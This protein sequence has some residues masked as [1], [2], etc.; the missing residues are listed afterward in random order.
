MSGRPLLGHAG[1]SVR[2]RVDPALE[3][4]PLGTESFAR[5]FLSLAGWTRFRKFLRSV[6]P[7]EGLGLGDLLARRWIFQLDHRAL[8]PGALDDQ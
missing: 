5:R 7:R 6:P 2:L 1:T 3:R 4:A 8:D